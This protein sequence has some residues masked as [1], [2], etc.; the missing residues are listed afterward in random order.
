M[1]TFVE[2]LCIMPVVAE[3]TGMRSL[4]VA[5]HTPSHAVC[6]ELP[7]CTEKH[8]YGT[9]EEPPML[10]WQRDIVLKSGCDRSGL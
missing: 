10:T 7:Y 6:F 1:E 3:S 9:K 2:A 8:A 4:L 5:S